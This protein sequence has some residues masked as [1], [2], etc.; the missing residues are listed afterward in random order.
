MTVL[1]SRFCSSGVPQVILA[2]WWDTY[3][4]AARVEYLGVGVF[5]N[6]TAAPLAATVELREALLKVIGNTKMSAKAKKLALVC[7]R[8]GE[9]R[10]RARN[11]IVDIQRGGVA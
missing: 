2:S 9:G 11:L 10:V 6:K 4:Y 7:Q 8:N 3:E 1:K 5:A